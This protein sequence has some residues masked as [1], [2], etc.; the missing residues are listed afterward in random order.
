MEEELLPLIETARPGPSTA[1]QLRD[2]DDTKFINCAVTAGVRW[3]VS[4]DEDL[5]SLHRVQSVEIV[6]V[7][8]FLQQLKGQP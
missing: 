1:P 5:V 8:V 6:S 3:L 4:G 7:A 2:L